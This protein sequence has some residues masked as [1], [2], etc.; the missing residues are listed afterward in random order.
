M[1]KQPEMSKETFLE[2]ARQLDLPGP[3]ERLDA[4]YEDV[5]T[6]LQRIGGIHDVD[7]A[8]VEASPISPRFDGGAA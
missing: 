5:Q 8:G 7:T 4:L 1:A 6:L 3:E 2:M